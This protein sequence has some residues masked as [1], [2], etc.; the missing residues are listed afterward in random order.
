[1][2]VPVF[3][4]KLD[5]EG[6]PDPKNDRRWARWHKKQPD[7][8]AL[9]SYKPG[10]ALCAVTG[11]V[12]DVIDW[13]PRNDPDKKSFNR[14]R[15][16]LGEGGPKIYW[17]VAT[18]RRG[19]HLYV[20]KL[21]V[22]SHNG[23]LPG[24][25][26]KS[27]KSDGTGRGFVFLPGTERNGGKYQPTSRL[28]VLNGV[29][30]ASGRSLAEFIEQCLEDQRN[31]ADAAA[32]GAKREQPDELKRA[33][34][35]AGSGE[36]R[37]ALLRY[38]HELERRGYARDDIKS[39]LRDVCSQMRNF[40]SK[41]P[42]Y[43][44]R[45]NPDK[46]INGLFHRAG[47]V[48]A[49]GTKEELEGIRGPSRPGL[50]RSFAEVTTR[51]ISWVYP[52]YLARGEMTILDGEKGVAK[53]LTILD[54]LARLTEGRDLPN[55]EMTGEKMNVVIFT[56]ESSAETEIAPRLQAAGANLSM[57]HAPKIEKDKR[58]KVK[59]TWILPDGFEAFDRAIRECDAQVAVFDPINDF[60]QEDINTNNDASIRR[61]LGPLGRVLQQ[62]GCAGWLVRHMNKDTG[63]SARMRGTGTTAYQN[64]A[65]IHMVAGRLPPGAVDGARFGL[66]VVDSNI[67]KV[68]DAV[69]AYNVVDSDIEADDAGGMV[70]V[71][72]WFGMCN[73]KA[74][75]LVKENTGKRRGPEPVAQEAIREVL[76]DMFSRKDTW[77][78]ARVLAELKAAG[79]ST[80]EKTINKVR[81]M[82]GINAVRVMRRG[83][84][85]GGVDHWNWT[86]LTVKGRVQVQGDD[87]D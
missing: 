58:G 29:P 69:L 61:A 76:D 23:F 59:E 73:V 60:L 3:A 20:A 65:R 85:G 4:A 15:E 36:Q 9:A 72:E 79:C 44:A 84:E 16:E 82:M 77:A 80:N 22:G 18:P 11:I 66:A 47:A 40:D 57:V 42:W 86:N 38:V 25:D 41:D 74:D 87:D 62:T 50:M 67:R 54:V 28:Q 45:G 34:L 17:Q 6:D 53:S 33:V 13:D 27:G 32:S 43:P 56:N 39:I 83:G 48:V 71:V 19:R 46:H 64:R 78:R 70:P 52:P 5:D 30:D 49:D 26:V 63:A 14:L 31:A 21:G 24:I 7:P 2:G 1:M 81:D 68:E 35:T 51:K 37:T 8:A 10:D 12:F 55:G 75:D